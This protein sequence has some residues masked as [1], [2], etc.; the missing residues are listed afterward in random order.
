VQSKRRLWNKDSLETRYFLS[1]LAVDAATFARYI[2]AH[3]G[4]ENQ[5]HWCLDVVFNEDASRIG[6]DHAPR[7]FSVLRRFALNLLRQDTSK[8]SLAMKRYKAG[9]DEQFMVQ[10]LTPLLSLDTA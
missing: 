10:I 1:S 2:R 3:W 9:L 6:Q 5:L 8:G 7:N 4:I